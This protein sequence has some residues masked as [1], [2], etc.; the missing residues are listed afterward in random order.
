VVGTDDFTLEANKAFDARLAALGIP[1]EFKIVPHV[2]HG[3]KE[4]YEILDFSFFKTIGT[5]M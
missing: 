4:Y 3:Y 1:H 2:S 5:A